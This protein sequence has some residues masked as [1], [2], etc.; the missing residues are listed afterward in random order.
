[1]VMNTA[2]SP[3]LPWIH[4]ISGMNPAVASRPTPAAMPKPDARALVGNTSDVK[5]CSVFPATW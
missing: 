1:M 3:R 4:G 5:I 2:D